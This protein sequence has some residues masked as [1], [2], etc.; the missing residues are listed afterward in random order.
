M[1]SVMPAEIL[2]RGNYLET[3]IHPRK[4]KKFAETKKT[5]R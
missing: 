2:T 5:G 4:L 1:T 3:T